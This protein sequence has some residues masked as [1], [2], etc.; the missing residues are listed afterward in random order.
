MNDQEYIEHFNKI[1][2]TNI[3][4]RINNMPLLEKL[5]EYFEEDLYQP[6]DKY[7][8]LRAK[9]RVIENKLEST[10]NK[11]QKKLFEK[12][13]E[14]ENNAIQEE[15]QQLFMFGY[16]VAIQLMKEGDNCQKHQNLIEGQLDIEE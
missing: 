8:K 13:W 9:K 12:Y 15:Q 6:S 10:F 7:K 5:F 14:T 1:F 4:D 16:L 3:T 2:G 11:Q